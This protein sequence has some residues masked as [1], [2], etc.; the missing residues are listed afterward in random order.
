[1]KRRVLGILLAIAMVSSLAVGC[2]SGS[3]DSTTTE[4]KKETE[5]KDEKKTIKIA[6]TAVS[7]VFYEAFKEKYEAKG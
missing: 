4:T 1:M 3:K 2:G 7:E 5:S 6:G